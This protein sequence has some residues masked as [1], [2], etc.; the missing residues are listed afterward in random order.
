MFLKI[1]IKRKQCESM[2]PKN[3]GILIEALR[4]CPHVCQFIFYVIISSKLLFRELFSNVFEFS[5]LLL[6]C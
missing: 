2:K 4:E 5:W 6:F 1:L 3:D